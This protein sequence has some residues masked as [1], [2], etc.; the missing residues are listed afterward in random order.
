MSP[1]VSTSGIYINV[2]MCKSCH[3]LCQGLGWCSSVG[4]WWCRKSKAPITVMWDD[5]PSH[6]W[7]IN[8][9]NHPEH[10]KPAQVFPP[11]LTRQEFREIGKHDGEGAPNTEEKKQHKGKMRIF[12]N[13]FVVR[14]ACLVREGHTHRWA[15]QKWGLEDKCKSLFGWTGLRHQ[16]WTRSFSCS[17]AEFLYSL[18]KPRVIPCSSLKHLLLLFHDHSF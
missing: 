3:Y 2:G 12:F 8:A 15:A 5:A 16:R 10:A 7:S 18:Y 14:I 1:S 6:C 11:L 9:T 13:A 4:M 17:K